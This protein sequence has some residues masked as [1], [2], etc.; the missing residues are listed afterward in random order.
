MTNNATSEKKFWFWSILFLVVG[1]GGG[2]YAINWRYSLSPDATMSVAG[3]NLSTLAI[4]LFA[5]ALC[6][7][8]ML[9]MFGTVSAVHKNGRS[10]DG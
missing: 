1:L 2:T 8:L 10:I 9:L 3:E 6:Y 7:A 4:I 5:L